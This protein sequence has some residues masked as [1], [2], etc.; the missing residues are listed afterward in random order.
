M[1]RHNMMKQMVS[2]LKESDKKLNYYPFVNQM[3]AAR[4]AMKEEKSNSAA[5]IGSNDKQL[6][7]TERSTRHEG[8]HR[9]AVLLL[10]I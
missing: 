9:Q 8:F 10:P 1:F 4:M 2:A 6:A 5:A 3:C 7:S